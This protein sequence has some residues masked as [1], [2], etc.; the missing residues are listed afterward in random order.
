VLDLLLL[1]PCALGGTPIGLTAAFGIHKLAPADPSALYVEAGL[2][3][4][5]FAE[6]NIRPLHLKEHA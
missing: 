3:A 5:G 1:G 6:A 4:L 2:V